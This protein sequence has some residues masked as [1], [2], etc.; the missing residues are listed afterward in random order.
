MSHGSQH[1][2]GIL[3]LKHKFNGNI[4]FTQTDPHGHYIFVVFSYNNQLFLLGNVYGYNN[5]KENKTLLETL[6]NIIDA[7]LRKFSDM[8]V[9]LGG[10]FNLTI[11]DDVDRWPRRHKKNSV[12]FDFMNGLNLID[13]W[14]INNPKTKEFTWK[15]NSGSLQSRIDFWLISESL[16]YALCTAE[17]IPT[18]L[19]DHKAILLTLNMSLDKVNKR[20]PAY[21]KLNNSLLLNESLNVIIKNKITQYSKIAETEGAYGKYWELLKF[22]LRKLLMET[23]AKAKKD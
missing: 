22:E 18:P 12:M 23:G 20:T 10:D 2:A 7:L 1:S 16:P 15:N 8:K 11:N 3:T 4:I 17:I 13:I 21:W 5:A 19:S 6:N 14:R 9:I